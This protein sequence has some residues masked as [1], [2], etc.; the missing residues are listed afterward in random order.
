MRLRSGICPEPRWG[1]LQRSHKSLSWFRGVERRS[2]G[3]KRKG[4][5]GRGNG[6][7]EERGGEQDVLLFSRL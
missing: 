2:G 3:Q 7:E 5:G 1:S 4:I 6:K